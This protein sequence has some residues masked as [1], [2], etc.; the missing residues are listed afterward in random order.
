M[1]LNTNQIA[2]RIARSSQY[3]RRFRA[4]RGVTAP[5]YRRV[6][7]DGNRP[8][9]DVLRSI[10]V[11]IRSM[12]AFLALETQTMAVGCRDIATT[13][14]T[15]RGV[16]RGNTLRL[17]PFRRRFVGNKELPL[18]VRPAVDFRPELLAL[19]E[20]TVSYIAQIFQDYSAGPNGDGILN[21]GFT[22]NMQKLFC[23]GCLP[24]GQ[25]AQKPMGRSGANSLDRTA[26]SSNTTA[27]V[28]K[29]PAVE[30]K[31]FGVGRTS[32]RHQALNTEIDTDQT[33]STFRF[34]NFYLV[35]KDQKPS[36]ANSLKLG[37][38]PAAKRQLLV[39]Q[40]QRLTPQAYAFAFGNIEV[41]APNNWDGR[42]YGL[43]QTPAPIGFGCFIGGDDYFAQRAG[44][45]RSEPMLFSQHG[46]I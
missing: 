33:A 20:R 38:F 14:T 37:I 16:S 8:K 42:P 31:C 17:N 3:I 25:T 43:R 10:P 6:M 29:P 18:R 30:E 4:L 19:L 41:A 45:L 23:Y 32:G 24:A 5:S 22:S 21:Q 44:Q 11:R 1:N 46:V 7:L 13:R 26:S 34:G 40:I 9:S 35:A 28:I 39:T 12:A 36:F 27:E 2:E 15:S